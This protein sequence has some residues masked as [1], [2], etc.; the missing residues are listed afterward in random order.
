MTDSCFVFGFQ[1]DGSGSGKAIEPGTETISESAGLPTWYHLDYSAGDAERWMLDRGIPPQVAETL[2]R[3]DSRPRALTFGDGV[4]V[5]LR[6]VNSNPGAEPEDMV[7]LRLWIQRGRLISVRQRRLLSAQDVRATVEAGNGPVDIPDLVNTIIERVADRIGDFVDTIEERI[8]AYEQDVETDNPNEVRRDVTALRR[9]TAVV[10]RFLAP[11]RDALDSLY[12]HSLDILDDNQTYM[13]RE[14]SDRITRYVEDLDL[15]RERALVIQEELMNR[16]AQQQ[17]ARMYVLSIVAA[18]FLPI[19]FISGV[20][21]MNV[22]GLPGVE[23]TSSF[24]IL[25]GVMFIISAVVM[26]LFWIKRWF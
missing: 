9:Q 5:V 22:G 11:Q 12:R 25:T 8:D 4:L 17:N 18:V 7:S 3:S 19:T 10:R 21:G 23:E 1:L 15:I 14:Q 20:F 2:T 13:V 24:W 26:G 6:G 16:I